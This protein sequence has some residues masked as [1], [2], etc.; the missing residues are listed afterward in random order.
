MAAN[1]PR[2]RKIILES[3]DESDDAE[4]TVHTEYDPLS[5]RRKLSSVI[6]E[7]RKKLS[8]RSFKAD[9][10]TTAEARGVRIISIQQLSGYDSAGRVRRCCVHEP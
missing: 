3:E 10:G 1:P 2:R 9:E 6:A 8:W 4:R 7:E 5:V